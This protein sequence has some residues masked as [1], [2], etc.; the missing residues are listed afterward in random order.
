MTSLFVKYRKMEYTLLPDLAPHKIHAKIQVH[1]SRK[2][3]F[4][5]ATD[6]GPLQHVDMVLS[7]REVQNHNILTSYISFISI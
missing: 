6:S 5:G 3:L 2:W 4:R 1:V 7:D